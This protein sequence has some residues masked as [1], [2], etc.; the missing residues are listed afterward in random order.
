MKNI[1]IFINKKTSLTT[2]KIVFFV[3]GLL[4]TIVYPLIFRHNNYQLNMVIT[5]SIL[6]IISL[7]VWLTFVIGRINIGQ[8]AFVLIGAYTTAILL[9]KL[10]L[11]FWLCLPI[12]GMIAALLGFLIGI[13][14]LRLKGVYFDMLTLSLTEVVMLA[15]LN[16]DF[17]TQGSRGIMN[18]PIPG[19]LKIGSLTIIPAFTPGKYLSFYYLT[20]SLLII[21]LFAIWRLYSSRIGWNMQVLRQSDTLALSSGI[22]IAKYRLISY[23]I[24]C[25]LG[26]IGGSLFAVYIQSL[27]PASF[28]VIDSIY[29]MLYC[30]LGGLNY[31]IG[32]ILG[33]FLM[34]FSFEGLRFIQKYQEGIYAC[35]MIIFMLWLP[36]GLMSLKLKKRNIFK[37][38]PH[39]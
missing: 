24:C 33:A 20:A 9:V 21:I 19:A 6:S 17:L 36:N 13:P 22:N 37:K 18:I 38:Q 5:A 12:S 16:L 14:I 34:T 25:F 11:S 31:L 23:T 7:G 3:V 1:K 29:Y 30:F 35:L 2:T 27:F 32:P 15:M 10:N 39:E 4:Y 26:G 28:K 8:G